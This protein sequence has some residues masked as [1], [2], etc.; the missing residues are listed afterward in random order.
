MASDGIGIESLRKSLER[1]QTAQ[2]AFW[3][4]LGELEAGLQMEVDGT[5][6]LSGLTIEDL[7]DSDEGEAEDEEGIG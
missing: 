5:C 6:D 7:L 2:D 3:D 4:A 1:A